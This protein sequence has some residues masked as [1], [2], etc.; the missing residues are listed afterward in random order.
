MAV[1]RNLRLGSGST[2]HKTDAILDQYIKEIQKYKLLTQDEEVELAIKI[3]KGDEVA[4]QKLITANLRFVISVAKQFQHQG[5][6]LMDLINEG[7]LGLI[8]AASKYDETRGFKFVSFAVW[9]IR[10]HINNAVSSQARVVR[11]PLNRIGNLSKVSKAIKKLKQVKIRHQG[12][13]TPG[14]RKVIN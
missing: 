1:R 10:Q 4:R 7:N 14:S 11:L 6:E 9:Y 2:S 3:K 8:T 5:L 12:E 13:C